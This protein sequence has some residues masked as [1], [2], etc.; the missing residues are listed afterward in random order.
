[1]CGIAGLIL[2]RPGNIGQL[3]VQMLDGCQHRGPGSTGFAIY[4]EQDGGP[5]ICRIYLGC[6]G[7]SPKARDLEGKVLAII[8]EHGGQVVNKSF[9]QEHLRLELN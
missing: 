7:E 3:L 9:Q 8:A 2:E 5:L 1:M 6:R 4:H